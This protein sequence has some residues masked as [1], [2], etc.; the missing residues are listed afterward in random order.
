MQVQCYFRLVLDSVRQLD[1]VIF[2]LVDK[3][4]TP[5]V[6]VT[7]SLQALHTFQL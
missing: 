2:R 1:S 6:E 5:D 3:L 4:L 7:Y